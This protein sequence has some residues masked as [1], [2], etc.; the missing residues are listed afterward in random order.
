MKIYMQDLKL[1]YLVA[2]CCFK[3]IAFVDMAQ[4]LHCLSDIMQTFFTTKQPRSGL[5]GNINGQII[6]HSV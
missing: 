1:V 4:W 2:K 5:Y 6:H 3:P